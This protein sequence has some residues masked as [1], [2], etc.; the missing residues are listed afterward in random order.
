M[1]GKV[2]EQTH[3]TGIERQAQCIVNRL[4]FK[5]DERVVERGNAAAAEPIAE[6]V[7]GLR[8]RRVQFAPVEKNMAL[9]CVQIN[10]KAL[11]A[12]LPG[13]AQVLDAGEGVTEGEDRG[14]ISAEAEPSRR[15]CWRSW[16]AALSA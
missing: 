8:C 3:H 12:K 2:G 7:P 6:L 1:L 9:V 5:I 10:G 16:P 14:G 15:R 13:A 11:L 4:E